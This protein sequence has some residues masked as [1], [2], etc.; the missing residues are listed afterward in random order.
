MPTVVRRHDP[1]PNMLSLEDRAAD[2]RRTV[3]WALARDCAVMLVAMTIVVAAASFRTVPNEAFPAAQAFTARLGRVYDDVRSQDLEMATGPTEFQPDVMGARVSQSRWA[4][5]GQVDG[6]CYAM[7]WD[8]SGLRR[9]RVI[10]TTVECSPANGANDSARMIAR[11]A[12]AAHASSG[13]ANWD[14]LWPDETRIQL[15]WWPLVFV[16]GAIALSAFVRVVVRLVTGRST[17]G[18]R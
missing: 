18:M 8:A 17:R 7:W 6:V 4:V 9:I 5:A 14:A 15:W 12:P 10:P 1:D 3:V 16:A 11:T 13:D 2:D